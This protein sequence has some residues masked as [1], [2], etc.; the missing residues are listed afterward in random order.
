[1]PT[2]QRPSP[3]SRGFTLIELLVVIAIIALLIG[4]LLPALGSARC[5]GRSLVSQTNMRQIST[6]LLTYATDSD[7]FFPPNIPPTD[8]FRYPDPEN[9]G[10]FI[11]GRRWFD[12]DVLGDYL[13]QSD[14]S[15]VPTTPRPIR[16]R[17]ALSGGV[18][19]D[20]NQP[21]ATRSYAMNWWASSGVSVPLGA[22]SFDSSRNE[23]RRWYKPGDPNINRQEGDGK[24][25]NATVDFASQML[26][27]GGAWG[28]YSS[29][30]RATSDREFF[31][32]E[33][34]GRT[35]FPGERFGGGEGVDDAEFM[36]GNWDEEGSPELDNP[37]ELPTSYLPYYRAT[38]RTNDF[39]SLEGSA[40]IGFADGSVRKKQSSDL[41]NNDANGTS[42]GDVLWSPEDFK[43]ERDRGDNP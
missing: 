34:I 38:C 4:I 41:F 39:Q 18:F 2:A 14:L 13:P 26:L 43:I 6:A 17:A 20:P 32:E 1:M 19:V 35:G 30:D 3:S 36:F 10:R 11:A 21:Q 24:P 29:E 23:F 5:A 37:E 22:N 31:G 28:Q 42:T 12:V 8:N 40:A 15:D 25:W 9:P 16:P 27:V 7:D 33:T